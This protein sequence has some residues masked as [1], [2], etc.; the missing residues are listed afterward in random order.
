[1]SRPGDIWILGH[2]RIVCGD[3]TE[4]ETVSK[5]LGNTKPHLMVTDPPYGVAYDPTWRAR[6]G[7]NKNRGK[8]GKVLND[9][10]ADWRE[11]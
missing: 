7:V 11:A 9:E 5:V 6:A 2:H 10:R 3:C 1:M 4:A 8:M